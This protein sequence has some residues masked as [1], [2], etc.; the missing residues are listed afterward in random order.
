MPLVEEEFLQGCPFFAPLG[1]PG[2]ATDVIEY[3]EFGQGVAFAEGCFHSFQ[4]YQEIGRRQ[5]FVLIEDFPF[6][7][8]AGIEFLQGRSRLA[9]IFQD[10]FFQFTF[11]HGALLNVFFHPRPASL[12]K[13]LQIGRLQVF[14]TDIPRSLSGMHVS[15]PPTRSDSGTGL[16]TVRPVSGSWLLSLFSRQTG[17]LR[18]SRLLLL[19]SRRNGLLHG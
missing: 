13:L 5:S 2:Q 12:T 1:K 8:V 3:V 9:I 15:F 11:Q 4:K 7:G 16:S 6:G 18:S 14:Q 17:G 10:A 19:P